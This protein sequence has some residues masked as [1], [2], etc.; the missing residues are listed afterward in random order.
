MLSALGYKDIDEFLSNVVPE[1]VL[2]KRKLSIQPEQGF[3]ESEML[4]HLQKLANKNKIKNPSLV[5]V[6]PVP[7]YHLL[8]KEIFLNLQNGILLTH[9]INQ[10]FLKVD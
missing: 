9:H 10:K 6:M 3:T 8:F 7:F 1:H 4:D 2:I 5:K